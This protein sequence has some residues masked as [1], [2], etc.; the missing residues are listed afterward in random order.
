MNNQENP[1]AAPGLMARLKT[2]TRSAHDDAESAP[3]MVSL[4]NGSLPVA[5]YGRAIAQLGLVRQRVEQLM[6]NPALQEDHML[7][8]VFRGHHVLS[9]Q[10][11]QDAAHWNPAEQEPLPATQEYLDQLDAWAKE[12][13]LSLLG[14]V[15]VLEGSNLGA[16]VIRKRLTELHNLPADQPGLASLNAHG[17]ELMN[18]WR[19]FVADMNALPLT[20]E[21][22]DDVVNAAS[23]TFRAVDAIHQGIYETRQQPETSVK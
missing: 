5:E 18:R 7:R 1:A 19:Q 10:F 4:M 20:A 14:A 12:S 11:M 3:F 8:S 21:Q 16:T 2:E 22:Q 23:V 9:S 17:P 15:Y 13:P 6:E